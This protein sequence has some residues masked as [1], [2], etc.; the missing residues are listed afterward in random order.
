MGEFE[1]RMKEMSGYHIERDSRGLEWKF[2][3]LLSEAKKEFQEKFYTS[4]EI[5]FERKTKGELFNYIIR[6]N[7][8]RDNWF[9]KWFGDNGTLQSNP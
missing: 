8:E 5:S 6:K 7:Q 3:E 2:Q 4:K 1:K 9:E